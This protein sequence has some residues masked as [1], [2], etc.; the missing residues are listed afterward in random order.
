VGAFVKRAGAKNTRGK[1]GAGGAKGGKIPIVI[2][3]VSCTSPSHR[4]PGRKNSRKTE[5]KKPRGGLFGGGIRK[6][7]KI[8]GS[9]S[10]RFFTRDEL[11]VGGAER[12]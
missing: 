1:H 3:E 9:R 7:N 12:G 5:C 10:G 8:K 11:G 6:P 2:T 4:R